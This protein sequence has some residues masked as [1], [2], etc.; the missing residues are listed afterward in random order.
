[1]VGQDYYVE[2]IVKFLDDGRACAAVGPFSEERK[3]AWIIELGQAEEI[4]NPNGFYRVLIRD[5]PCVPKVSVLPQNPLC[6]LES[7]KE[8]YRQE[9]AFVTRAIR[10]RDAWPDS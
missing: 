10:A 2:V 9:M 7:L 5:L 1:M 8:G 3:K 4:F 6:L